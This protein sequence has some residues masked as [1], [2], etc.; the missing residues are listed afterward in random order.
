MGG[1]VNSRSISVLLNA[2]GR[3]RPLFGKSTV[4]NGLVVMWRLLVR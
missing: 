1:G 4:A 2:L 3:V